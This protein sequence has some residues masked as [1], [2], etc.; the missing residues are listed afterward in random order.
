M[1]RTPV[2]SAD[3]LPQPA[4][5]EASLAEQV[6]GPFANAPTILRVLEVHKI[7][8]VEQLQ[9]LKSFYD[10]NPDILHDGSNWQ[11]ALLVFPKSGWLRVSEASPNRMLQPKQQQV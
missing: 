5:P 11:Q 7:L 6:L 3:T 9:N 10:Q 1:G 8:D 4:P 2:E